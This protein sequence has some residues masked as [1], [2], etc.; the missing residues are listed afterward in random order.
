[1]MEASAGRRLKTEKISAWCG[2]E[3]IQFSNIRELGVKLLSFHLGFFGTEFSE[4]GISLVG[5]VAGACLI[6]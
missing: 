3:V 1:M 4:I 2:H 6:G 5:S